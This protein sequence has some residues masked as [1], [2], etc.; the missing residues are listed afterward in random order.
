MVS[1][2]GIKDC[3]VSRKN[4]PKARFFKLPGVI[5]FDQTSIDLSRKRRKAWLAKINRSDLT[6][7]QLSETNSTFRVCGKHFI[8]GQ[9]S[10]LFESTDPDWAPSLELGY[11]VTVNNDPVLSVD[12]SNKRKRRAEN[13]NLASADVVINE[14]D[15]DQY[16]VVTNTEEFSNCKKTQ[17]D[18]F[19][20]SLIKD[21]ENLQDAN[22]KLLKENK[23]LQN[24]KSF[25]FDQEKFKHDTHDRV[26]YYTG[27]PGYDTLMTLFN[28]VSSDIKNGYLLSSFEKLILCLMRLRLGSELVDLADRFQISKST[29]STIF[30]E[31]LHV[32]F[33]KL[34]PVIYW[35]ERPELIASMP[36][37]FRVKFGTKIATIIDCFELFI[38]RPSNLT[39]RATTWSFY[40]NHNTVKYLI[41]ITPQGTVCFISKGWG[42]RASDQHIT[43]NSK[44]LKYLMYGDTVMADRGFNIAET[45]GAYGARLEIP[46]FTKGQSQL[47]PVE[48]EDTRFIANVRIHVERVI[49]NLR[50][51]YYILNKTLP[52][53]YMITKA[54]EIPTID[55]IV[56]TTCALINMCPSVV[57][58]E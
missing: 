29:V 30:H 31:V 26:I 16:D 47:R 6:E 49:G 50:K 44:F 35:P 53:D 2:C 39:A 52:I 14:E 9:P 10:K 18:N 57:P 58:L 13:K 42:G 12:R 41:G 15:E 22:R 27:L 1:S 5:K 24:I 48:V 33:I 32:L 51:K 40:K 21:I 34:S 11:K 25:K 38:D 45:L 43:E 46:A 8:K 3:S 55:K 4:T 19:L 20:E 23:E 7:A 37:S 56:H 54:G 28:L 36:M 17:T